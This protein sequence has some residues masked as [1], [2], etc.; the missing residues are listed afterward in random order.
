MGE[1]GGRQSVVGDALLL[2][3]GRWLRRDKVGPWNVAQNAAGVHASV[4][5]WIKA[6]G[7][8]FVGS[9]AALDVTPSLVEGNNLPVHTLMINALGINL[10]DNQDLEALSEAS[11][12]LNHWEFMLTVAP[13]PVTG[14]TGSPVNALCDVL[15]FDFK[16]SSFGIPSRSARLSTLPTIVFG[17]S[18]RNSNADGILYGARRSLQKSRS[19][20]C[21][22]ACPERRTI[23]AWTTSPLTESMTPATPTSAT[24]GCVAM[25]SSTSRG[26]TW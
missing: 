25:T 3:T 6:R 26:Q 10:L 13:V 12:R 22:D 20:D 2:R 17:S 15:N 1:K 7:V 9:D 23:Q 18:V 14:G 16:L 11:A 8:A 19:S 5:A 4:A 21:V 24:A